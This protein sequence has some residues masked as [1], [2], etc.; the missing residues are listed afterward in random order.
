MGII[1]TY[2]QHTNLLNPQRFNEEA[3]CPNK[4]AGSVFFDKHDRSFGTV[5]KLRYKSLCT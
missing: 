2:Q 3:L 1:S 4:N 5:K